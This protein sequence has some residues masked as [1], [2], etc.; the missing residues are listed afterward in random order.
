MM[1]RPKI[2]EGKIGAGIVI[3]AEK[4]NISL[5]IVTDITL[6]LPSHIKLVGPGRFELPT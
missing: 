3:T 1:F 2:D 4:L 6:E 5:L